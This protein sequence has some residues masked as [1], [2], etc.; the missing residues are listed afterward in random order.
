MRKYPC[1]CGGETR[2]AFYEEHTGGVLIKN[3]PVLVC[4]KCKEE[5]YPPSVPKM[6]EGIR[7]AIKSIG[8][9][10]VSACEEAIA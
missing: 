6:I 5:W 10:N 4:K 7:E 1:R 9:I 3:V 8:S 2:L